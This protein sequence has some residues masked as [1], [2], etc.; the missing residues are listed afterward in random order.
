MKRIEDVFTWD[1][2]EETGCWNCTSHRKDRHG[3]SRIRIKGRDTGAHRYAF[4]LSNGPI[5]PSIVVRHKCDNPACINPSHLIPGTQ[6]DNC[7]DKMIRN[8][9]PLREL[10]DSDYRLIMKSE[11][12]NTRLAEMLSISRAHVGKIRNGKKCL[13]II[14]HLGLEGYIGNL[15]RDKRRSLKEHQAKYILQNPQIKDTDLA[16][17]YGV[18]VMTIRRVRTGKSWSHLKGAKI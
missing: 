1:T 7:R 15:D 12:S 4:I 2:D 16:E 10:S 13:E 3:Y 5:E 9:N 8:R 17:K 14:K 11:L 18:H 6:K